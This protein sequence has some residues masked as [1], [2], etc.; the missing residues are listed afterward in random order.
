MHNTWISLG[1]CKLNISYLHKKDGR[2]FR[3]NLAA[4][5]SKGGSYRQLDIVQD[6][7]LF[8]KM[9][10]GFLSKPVGKYNFLVKLT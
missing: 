8:R 6:I 9:T 4:C 7:R 10:E 1:R 2:E 3:W 5:C